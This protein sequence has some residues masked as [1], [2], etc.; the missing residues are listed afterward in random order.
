LKVLG[1]VASPRKLGN[2]EILVKEM[3]ASLPADT[4]KEMIRLADL[5]IRACRACYVCLPEEK[6]CRVEDD[7]PFLLGRIKA[8]DAVVIA[9][10]CY[11]LGGHTSLK[12]IGDRLVSV[13]ANGAEFAGKKCVTATV[14]GIP[15]W[16]GY[17]REMVNNFA[18]FLH[19][20]VAGDMLVQAA[21][22]GEAIRPEVMADARQLA[23]RL[24]GAPSAAGAP[25]VHTCRDCGSSLLQLAP[26]GSVR[27]V[28]CG[29]TGE[30]KAGAA[31]FTLDFAPGHRRFSGEGMAEHA[32]LL[33]KIRDS[34]IASRGELSQ[35]R[36]PYG[37]YDWWVQPGSDNRGK[38][39]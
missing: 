25:G 2:S 22:P 11:F 10:A 34:F 32:R 3:L 5:D 16:E 17:A 31:G 28:M 20:E 27:C 13:L 37:E 7:L 33:D 35:R 12:T 9:S 24:I 36:K 1:L 26:S 19:L 21:S 8:A 23:Q 30:L 14:Y 39:N 4:D 38:E 29:A 6:G 18:R 15:G